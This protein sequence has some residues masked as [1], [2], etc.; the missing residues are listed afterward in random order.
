MVDMLRSEYQDYKTRKIPRKLVEKAL[1]HVSRQVQSQAS[2]AG[3]IGLGK[4]SKVHRSDFDEDALHG[5]AT[6]AHE[7]AA[8]SSGPAADSGGYNPMP[9]AR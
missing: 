6:T 2:A 5:S 4:P 3:R 8:A 7:T 1:M 9:G